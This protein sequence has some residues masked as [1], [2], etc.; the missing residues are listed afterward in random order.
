MANRELQPLGEW[1]GWHIVPAGMVSPQVGGPSLHGL[2]IVSP[3]KEHGV[4]ALIPDL[5]EGHTSEES[6]NS[7]RNIPSTYDGWRHVTWDGPDYPL[8][9]FIES[10]QELPDKQ[11]ARFH[12]HALANEALPDSI[13]KF[14]NLAE[15]VI[16][17]AIK[18]EP[19]LSYFIANTIIEQSRI[20]A[21]Q[22]RKSSSGRYAPS[23][24]RALRTLSYLRRQATEAFGDNFVQK[25]LA[26]P[27]DEPPKS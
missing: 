10:G 18:N 17:F 22:T 15:V 5:V 9:A 26:A 16:A 2:S 3:Y 4:Q 23:Y 19:E 12:I 1:E 13:F 8:Q 25:M 11:K 7:E 27:I 21:M 6:Y 20:L 24:A 14:D